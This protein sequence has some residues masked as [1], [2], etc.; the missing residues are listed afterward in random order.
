MAENSKSATSVIPGCWR[1]APCVAITIITVSPSSYP[2]ESESRVGKFQSRGVHIALL[3]PQSPGSVRLSVYVP[4]WVPRLPDIR[5]KFLL[6]FSFSFF[7]FSPLSRHASSVDLSFIHF[8]SSY[9]YLPSLIHTAPEF[10]HL[11][12]R[13]GTMAETSKHTPSHHITDLF[14]EVGVSRPLQ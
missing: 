14:Q 2:L 13:H 3:W 8:G 11:N 6:L 9:K 5:L 4:P 12:F 10:I 1:W 7:L